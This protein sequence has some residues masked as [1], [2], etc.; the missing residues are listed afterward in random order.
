MSQNV[1]GIY[2][3]VSS[4]SGRQRGGCIAELASEFHESSSRR[5]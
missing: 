4:T 2:R 1:S 5:R 3:F